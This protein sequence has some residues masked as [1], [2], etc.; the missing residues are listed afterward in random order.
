MRSLY[1]ALFATAVFAIRDRLVDKLDPMRSDNFMKSEEISGF[2]RE[3]DIKTPIV[4][5]SL[6]NKEDY[7]VSIDTVPLEIMAK[8]FERFGVTYWDD[9]EDEREKLLSALSQAY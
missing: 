9:T 6:Q 7:R 3:H 4:K 1:L 5:K 8:D 2:G